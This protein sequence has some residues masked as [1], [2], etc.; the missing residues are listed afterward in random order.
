MNQL[1]VFSASR[2]QKH[3]DSCEVCFDAK[4]TD[5]ILIT[6]THR[7]NFCETC[8]RSWFK[9]GKFTCPKCRTFWPVKDYLEKTNQSTANI[10]NVSLKLKYPTSSTANVPPPTP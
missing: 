2:Y 10:A 9:S 8:M 6:C 5:I 1:S 4:P 3:D 7:Q